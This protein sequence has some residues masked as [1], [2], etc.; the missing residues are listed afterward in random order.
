M[1]RR[2]P[3][4]AG[5]ALV[6]G[7]EG[8]SAALGMLRTRLVGGW[9]GPEGFGRLDTALRVIPFL[10][11]LF[12]L[13]MTNAIGR[14]I[15]QHEAGRTQGAFLRAV[16]SWPVGLCVLAGALVALFPGTLGTFL[17]GTTPS[18][19]FVLAFAV[20]LPA[21]LMF[22]LA[23]GTA[24]GLR[25][26]GSRALMQG[27]SAV[28]ILALSVLLIRWRP[29]PSAALAAIA[30]GTLGALALGILALGRRLKTGGVLD[31]AG[32]VALG[33]Q[34]R[35]LGTGLSLG[36]VAVQALSALDRWMLNRLAGP[37]AAGIYAMG[38][39]W[40][41][42]AITP[43][44]FLSEMSFP[45]MSAA[46]NAGRPRLCARLFRHLALAGILTCAAAVLAALPLMSRWGEPLLG[47][48]FAGALPV[49][50]ALLLASFGRLCHTFL[51]LPYLLEERYLATGLLTVGGALAFAVLARL[52]IPVS[53]VQGAAWASALA[54]GGT[55]AAHAL[56][57]G[58][59]YRKLLLPTLAI[60]A[61]VGAVCAM[62]DRLGDLLWLLPLVP[63]GAWLAATGRR[64][65]VWL[66][67]R[68]GRREA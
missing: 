51:L 30:A 67:V 55:A 50:P 58:P 65:R 20:A 18:L 59:A 8:L 46:L 7:M 57:L 24:N 29:G 19:P 48:G 56:L 9:I 62:P 11:C 34:L 12:S 60:L 21:A 1:T 31:A 32:R 22:N 6:F 26:Y 38:A 63:L 35:T 5:L 27:A 2:L 15:T 40:A 42:L 17:L 66:A 44:M 13:G 53:P 28:G 10:L 52:W 33:V 36:L 4:A 23:I 45:S 43:W 39:F 14:Y 3:L 37:A 68:L 16:A 54:W 49:M 61:G 25:S 47:A 64:D 41:L